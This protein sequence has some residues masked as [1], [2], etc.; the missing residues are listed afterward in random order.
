MREI[1]RDTSNYGRNIEALVN[2]SKVLSASDTF[3]TFYLNRKPGSQYVGKR[4]STLLK[5]KRFMDTEV[6]V[7]GHKEGKG[8]HKG[9]MGALCCRL[10][11]GKKVDV[12]IGFTDQQVRGGLFA[13]K[14]KKK[15]KNSLIIYKNQ[16]REDPPAPGTIITIRYQ[17][18]TEAG[19]PRFPSYVGPAIDK[20]W[21]PEEPPRPSKIRK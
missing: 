16:Q 14:K 4:S 11:N 9:R 20:A 18:L 2:G 15:K 21:P 3:L 17:E 6:M 19:I 5:V 1:L 10:G 13:Y 8:K 12:G 7:E